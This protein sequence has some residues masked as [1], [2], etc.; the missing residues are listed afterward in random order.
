MDRNQPKSAPWRTKIDP[1]TVKVALG[2]TLHN[3]VK[4]LRAAVKSLQHQ[5]HGDFG[6]VL[7]DDQS[8][9]ATETIG[10]RYERKDDRIR[11]FRNKRRLG[12]TETWRRAFWLARKTYPNA[13]YF[14]WI[15][16][17]DIW[18]PTWLATMLHVLDSEDEILLVYPYTQKI[19]PS[20]KTFSY[21]EPTYFD[22][23]G[24]PDLRDRWRH[25][26]AHLIGA[27]NMVYGLFRAE[28]L[29]RAGVF[30]NV[31][32]PDRLLMAELTI[33][34]QFQQVPKVLWKRRDLAVSS[35]GRQRRTLFGERRPPLTAYLPWYVVHAGVLVLRNSFT[36][37]GAARLGFWRLVSMAGRYLWAQMFRLC[38]KSYWKW[39]KLF[40]ARRRGR[41]VRNNQSQ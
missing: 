17:H 3:N 24:M 21:I 4:Y 28:S 2:M 15:S 36:R 40:R 9:D 31:I 32:M 12:M 6:L 26:C 38:R 8:S 10:R 13:K 25:M 39:R 5:T 37:P 30:R 11:Y 35:V 33:Q 14:S 22:T 34:G 1:G 23:A 27:G 16:D 29:E 7:V 41:R 18:S 20:G 19:T